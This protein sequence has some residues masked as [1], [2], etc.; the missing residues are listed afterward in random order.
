[1]TSIPASDLLRQGCMSNLTTSMKRL[2]FSFGPRPERATSFSFYAPKSLSEL[3]C[4][5]PQSLRT[6]DPQIGFGIE[7][8]MQLG[9]GSFAAMN[10][11]SD[12]NRGRRAAAPVA[13]VAALKGEASC[14]NS[15]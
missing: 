15:R 11:Y 1:M 6:F 12:F 8:G 5:Q 13:A 2:R 4:L 14:P 7:A 10:A 3:K 9:A